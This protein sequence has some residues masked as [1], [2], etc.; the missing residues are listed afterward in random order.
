V[1]STVLGS[2]LI[3]IMT[4]AGASVQGKEMNAIRKTLSPANQVTYDGLSIFE[5]VNL[6]NLAKSMKA[7]P[8]AVNFYLEN[9]RNPGAPFASIPLPDGMWIGEF[10]K[11]Y[12]SDAVTNFLKDFGFNAEAFAKLRTNPQAL[13]FYFKNFTETV[14]E[15]AP[16]QLGFEISQLASERDGPAVL[17]FFD[18]FGTM[19]AAIADVQAHPKALDFFLTEKAIPGSPIA[20]L[21]A[22]DGFWVGKLAE[23]Y[24]P[25]SVIEYFKQRGVSPSDL[26]SKLKEGTAKGLSPEGILIKD[27][28]PKNVANEP[29]VFKSTQA[30]YKALAVGIN[31]NSDVVIMGYGKNPGVFPDLPPIQKFTP[32]DILANDN[33]ASAFANNTLWDVCK[34]AG[35]YSDFWQSNRIYFL[36][37]LKARK[38]FVLNIP[39]E[40][41]GYMDLQPKVTFAELKLIEY[42]SENYEW[43]LYKGYDVFVPKEKLGDFD[44]IL[45]DRLKKLP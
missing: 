2:L 18:E 32:Y 31:D 27:L 42:Y 21:T 14:I 45:E 17:G 9:I 36:E 20:S 22:Q 12:G 24:A 33:Q 30:E 8:E 29:L 5:R 3:I 41:V 28:E 35:A 44:V 39:Y 19:D 34:Q 1:R 15:K 16:P 26:L 37:G 23:D 11:S 4:M 10:A 6:T 38:I 7:S 40:Y 13:D 25:W 43:R